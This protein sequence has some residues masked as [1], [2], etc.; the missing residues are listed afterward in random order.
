MFKVSPL[1]GD[2]AILPIGKELRIFGAADDGEVV[3]TKLTA[4]DGTVTGE[5]MSTA[6][7]GRFLIH[8]PPQRLNRIPRQS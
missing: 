2:H 7:N 1:F 4:A 5:G 3:R 8:L 6:R